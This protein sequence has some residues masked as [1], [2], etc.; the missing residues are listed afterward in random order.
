VFLFL[1]EFVSQPPIIIGL[2][3]VERSFNE[4]KFYAKKTAERERTPKK[5]SRATL[6]RDGEKRRKKTKNR[7][8][9]FLAGK[10]T[11]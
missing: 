9:I 3:L 1:F 6:T 8:R 11:T 7:E 10:V 2:F 4:F 5:E